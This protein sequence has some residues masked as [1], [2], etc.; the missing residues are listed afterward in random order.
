MSTLTTSSLHYL[1]PLIL[2]TIICLTF[3]QT[4]SSP[5]ENQKS[6]LLETLL[7]NIL[8]YVIPALLLIKTYNKQAVCL[9]TLTLILLSILSSFK[10]FS[11][12]FR[13][14]TILIYTGY[15]YNCLSC[16]VSSQMTY[17][18]DLFIPILLILLTKM[19]YD[20]G[21]KVVS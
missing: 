1:P 4:L 10:R 8:R 13:T 6:K 18:F 7:S 2:I 14:A 9:S 11:K 21:E 3:Y 19:K 17:W 15:S 20:R 12:G 5:H 16:P